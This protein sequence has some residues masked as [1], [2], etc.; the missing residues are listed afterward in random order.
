MRAQVVVV[1]TFHDKI[2]LLIDAVKLRRDYP[3][4]KEM[5]GMLLKRYVEEHEKKN[6]EKSQTVI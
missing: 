3:G 4:Y 2:Y 1:L 6:D 5:F